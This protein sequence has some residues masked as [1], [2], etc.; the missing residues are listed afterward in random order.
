[1]SQFQTYIMDDQAEFNKHLL[2]LEA[3]V[4][5]SQAH[6][7]ADALTTGSKFDKTG[8]S[9]DLRR[10]V[11]FCETV[12]QNVALPDPGDFQNG[13]EIELEPPNLDIHFIDIDYIMLY[14]RN[15]DGPLKFRISN[16]KWIFC[17]KWFK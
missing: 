15:W 3:L 14:Q 16:G 13:H 10:I 8:R 6:S 11:H 5:F 1:M 4:G 2:K 12:L 17:P 9:E 7:A